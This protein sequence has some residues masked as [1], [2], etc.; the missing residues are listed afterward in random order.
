MAPA[1]IQLGDLLVIDE[2]QAQADFFAFQQWLGY[3]VTT[4]LGKVEEPALQ[5][6]RP[7]LRRNR[8]VDVRRCQRSPSPGSRQLV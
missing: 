7:R 5:G 2:L 4:G 1:L 8:V 6:G 3:G